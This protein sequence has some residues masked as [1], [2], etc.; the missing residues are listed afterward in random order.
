MWMGYTTVT[1]PVLVS[2]QRL[3]SGNPNPDVTRSPSV[4]AS[5]RRPH[6]VPIPPRE[7]LPP[8]RRNKTSARLDALERAYAAVADDA[9]QIPAQ[10]L[11]QATRWV[12]KIG[13]ALN[14][15]MSRKLDKP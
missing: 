9:S 10:D 12:H 1:S 6:T 13:A 15:Q 3:M 11:V 4:G 5:S 8:L 2:C 14:E 7:H